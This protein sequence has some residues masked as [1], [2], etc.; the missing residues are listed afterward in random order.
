MV[1]QPMQYHAVV[2]MTDCVT[3]SINFLLSGLVFIDQPLKVC[4]HDGLHVKSVWFLFEVGHNSNSISEGVSKHQEG[5]AEDNVR[6][7]ATSMPKPKGDAS[8]PQDIDTTVKYHS[9]D[10]GPRFTNGSSGFAP[11]VWRRT[12][13]SVHNK[14]HA[15]W[16]VA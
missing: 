13:N 14:P 5:A 9:V 11:S 4:S 10:S 8:A 15:L 6:S 7:D 16:E 2:N 3:R 1:T 12:R